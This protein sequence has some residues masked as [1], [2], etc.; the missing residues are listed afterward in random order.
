MIMMDSPAFLAAQHMALNRINQDKIANNIAN[1]TAGFQADLPI[2]ASYD[3]NKS[4]LDSLSFAVSG[5][6]FRDI[7]VGELNHTDSAFDIAVNTPDV[8]LA[9]QDPNGQNL[10]TR[11]G[12]LELNQ[13]RQLIQSAS[14]FPL[15]R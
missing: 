6:R 5:S 7:T 15:A 13:D 12:H 8:Y 9:V 4:T 2:V 11:N 3:P 14:G 10:Y 1:N